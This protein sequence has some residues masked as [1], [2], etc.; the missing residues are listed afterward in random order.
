MLSLAWEAPWP[1]ELV[2]EDIL[3]VER[4]A[5]DVV[6]LKMFLE[7]MVRNMSV[8]SVM[9]EIEESQRKV[10]GLVVVLNR[11][12]STCTVSKCPPE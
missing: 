4:V 5:D 2:V 3:I 1:E 8:M 9:R 6:C 10:D 11:S 12:S 7:I